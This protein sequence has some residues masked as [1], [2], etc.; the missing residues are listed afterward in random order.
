MYDDFEIKA[1]N[2]SWLNNKNRFVA[3]SVIYS[4]EHEMTMQTVG[5]LKKCVAVRGGQAAAHGFLKQTPAF[6]KLNL[7]Q[8]F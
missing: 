2:Y 8:S 7:V 5:K 3:C 6:T 4:I 1:E